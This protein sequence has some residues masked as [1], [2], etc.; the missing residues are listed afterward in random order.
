MFSQFPSRN[1]LSKTQMKDFRPSQIDDCASTYPTKLLVKS[2]AAK[3]SAYI[4]SP[5]SVYGHMVFY[6]MNIS[7]SMLRT[8]R[9]F[10][11]RASAGRLLLCTYAISIALDSALIIKYCITD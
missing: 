3:V 9:S 11:G 7:Q 2:T 8:R 1:I 4:F 6:R 5:V 10:I